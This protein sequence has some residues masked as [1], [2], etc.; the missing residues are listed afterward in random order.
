MAMAMIILVTISLVVA[1]T[2]LFFQKQNNDYHYKRML[3]KERNVQRSLDYYIVEKGVVAMDGR[4]EHKIQ[5]LA[6]INNLDINVYDTNGVLLGSTDYSQVEAGNFPE[7]L[8]P[9]IIDSVLAK[10]VPV[11]EMSENNSF[12]YMSSYFLIRNAL[13]EPMAVIHLPY[14][15]DEIQNK[16]DLQGFLVSLAWITLI[17]VVVSGLIGLTLGRY[18]S[19]SFKKITQQI[20]KL[21][22]SDSTEHLIWE[23]DDEIGALVEQY[24][25]K[26]DELRES[27]EKLAQKERESAWKEMARQVAHEVKNPLTPMQL[28]LQHL[29]RL[30]S[31]ADEH[32]PEHVRRVSRTLLDQIQTLSRIATE[33]SNFAQMPEGKPQRVLLG[34]LFK[35]ID[36]LYAADSAFELTVPEVGHSDSIFFDP[37]HALRILTNLIR[38]AKQAMAEDRE[39]RVDIECETFED[40]VHIRIIDNGTGIENAL[41]ER[42]FEPNFTTKSGGM[43][44]GLAM[45]KRLLEEAGGRIWFE[46]TLDQGTAFTLVF[47]R[48]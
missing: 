14:F 12:A 46:T 23:S 8:L 30:S 19:N 1:V 48:R 4:V 29:E 22:L 27:I 33:F 7:T 25:R 16:R 20:Q 11:V 13:Y 9:A 26:V 18:I 32:F 15:R 39:G 17:L 47:P 38:N 35:R 2:V 40:E 44:L 36:D 10:P 34:P 37:D 21:S 42:I 43:G 41:A 31:S 28:S 5:E 3:R 24:N 45:V 6:D